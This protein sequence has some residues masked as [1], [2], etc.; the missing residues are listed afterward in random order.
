MWDSRRCHMREN[1]GT[2]QADPFESCVR[3]CVN[4]VPGYLRSSIRIERHMFEG[5]VYLLREEV[6][7][8]STSKQLWKL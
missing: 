4:T 1:L 8:A 5:H 7:H 6:F 3:K 2:V